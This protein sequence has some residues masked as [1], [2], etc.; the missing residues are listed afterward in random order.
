MDGTLKVFSVF[1]VCCTI[2]ASVLMVTNHLNEKEFIEHGYTRT[3]FMGSSS[4]I[5]TKGDK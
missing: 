5:W 1:V 4:V 2:L 3:T